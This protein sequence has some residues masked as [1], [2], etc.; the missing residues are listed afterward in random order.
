MS[1]TKEAELV[2]MRKVSEAVGLTLRE[3][4]AYAKPGM[5]TKQLDEFGERLLT[6]FGAKSAP[7]L[8]Y[9]FPGCTFIITNKEFC[10]GIQSDKK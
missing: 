6:S 5:T 1:I 7:H 4:V 3:M 10:H 9:C 2:G 8:I